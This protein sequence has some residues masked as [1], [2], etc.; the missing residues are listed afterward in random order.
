MQYIRPRSKLWPTT[1]FNVI[2]LETHQ[3]CCGQQL[4]KMPVYSVKAS[5]VCW[6][7]KS[8]EKMDEKLVVKAGRQAGGKEGVCLA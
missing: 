7:Q 6:V 1:S 3:I 4:G 2:R 8:P 5:A